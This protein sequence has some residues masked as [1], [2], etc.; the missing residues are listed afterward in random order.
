MSI[1]SHRPEKTPIANSIELKIP[2]GWEFR[3]QGLLGVAGVIVLVL[4]CLY[5]GV[6][7]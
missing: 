2:G 5:V 6:K 1:P 7:F 4:C 3:A